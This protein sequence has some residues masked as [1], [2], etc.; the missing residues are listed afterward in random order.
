[1]REF[2]GYSQLP[3]S[4]IAIDVDEGHGSYFCS[5]LA[6]SKFNCKR[7]DLRTGCRD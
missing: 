6:K 7:E 5:G 4:W 2:F 3:N 1:M